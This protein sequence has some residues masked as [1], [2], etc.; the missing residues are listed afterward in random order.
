MTA[1][2]GPEVLRLVE[3]PEPAADT[4]RA[5]EAGRVIGKVVLTIG[6]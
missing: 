1:P 2:G 3:L 5:L 6:E 4:H